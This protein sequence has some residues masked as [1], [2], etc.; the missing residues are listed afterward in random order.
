MSQMCPEDRA[1]YGWH[2]VGNRN[3]LRIFLPW[4]LQLAL[5]ARHPGCK[6]NCKIQDISIRKQAYIIQPDI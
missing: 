6:H 2:P 3:Q 5:R 4:N 1:P